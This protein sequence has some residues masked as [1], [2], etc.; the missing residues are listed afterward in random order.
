LTTSWT[1]IPHVTQHNEADITDLEALRVARKEVLEARGVRLTLL[2]F[3]LRAVAITL[4]EMPR[5]NASL[6]PDG[7]RLALKRYCHLGFAADTPH[8]LV[9][10]VIRDVDQ[11]DAFEVA[12]E[13]AELSALA[14]AGRLTPTQMQGSTFTVSSLGGIGGTHFTPIVNPPEVAILGAGRARKVPGY[15]GARV[16]PRLMLPISLSYDHRVIDGVAG[17]RFTERIRGLLADPMTLI[18]AVP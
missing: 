5:F 11:K 9:V 14:R 13:L 17:V 2:A 3:L 16:E 12:R 8:G 7:E 1:T 4:A 15:V 18:A 10:P 6:C